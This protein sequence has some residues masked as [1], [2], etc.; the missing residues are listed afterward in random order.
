MPDIRFLFSNKSSGNRNLPR[1]APQRD[2]VS[3]IS[4]IKELMICDM[5]Y[6]SCLESAKCHSP[7]RNMGCL[8]LFETLIIPSLNLHPYVCSVRTE[9]GTWLI[10]QPLNEIQLHQ[11]V[12]EAE[13]TLTCLCYGC[14][15]PWTDELSHYVQTNDC[16]L[17]IRKASVVVKPQ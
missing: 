3:S 1:T 5:W 13:A 7:I 12:G 17:S 4:W 2:S 9:G 14:W 8:K 15:W 16:F 11:V 6:L 10:P